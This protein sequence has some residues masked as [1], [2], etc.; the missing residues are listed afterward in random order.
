MLRAKYA[1]KP[2]SSSGSEDEFEFNT[3]IKLLE[4][5]DSSL[6]INERALSFIK[7]LE[8]PICPCVIMGQ[9]RTGKSFLMSRLFE[10]SSS[11]FKVGHT[12]QPQTKG[13]WLSTETV[14]V[15]SKTLNQDMNLLLIDTEVSLV[16]SISGYF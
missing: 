15:R 5:N 8:G 11:A 7:N 2:C 13:I 10:R 12:D 6:K 16:L 14:K 1:S 3:P 4:K 9:Y